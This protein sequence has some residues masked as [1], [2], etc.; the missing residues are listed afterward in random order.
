[1]ALSRLA[2]L[3][4]IPSPNP[5]LYFLAKIEGN[6]SYRTADL[7]K[8]R[9]PANFP[10]VG[11]KHNRGCRTANPLKAGWVR[12]AVRRRCCD[13]RHLEYVIALLSAHACRLRVVPAWR[14]LVRT[15][16]QI[17][18]RRVQRQSAQRGPQIQGVA[19]GAF[20]A[21][22][23]LLACPT[24]DRSGSAVWKIGGRKAW[25]AS[26]LVALERCN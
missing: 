5:S 12:G 4:S 15:L 25:V 2:A 13:V 10:P 23:F 17:K 18:H 20:R 9:R 24:V 19:A 21:S 26:T 16:A 14:R 22:T 3:S 1:M 6:R 11:C 7:L 8:R